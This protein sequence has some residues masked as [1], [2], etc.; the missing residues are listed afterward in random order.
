MEVLNILNINVICGADRNQ[1]V[2]LL[3]AGLIQPPV[4][5]LLE[6]ATICAHRLCHECLLGLAG[7]LCLLCLF[8][9]QCFYM[10]AWSPGLSLV[11]GSN[12]HLVRCL[13]A[14]CLRL[15]P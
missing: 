5:F 8:I 9:E 7:D 2:P 4:T 13:P 15:C 12:H 3:Q 14:K 11:A 6:H 1:A 10:R